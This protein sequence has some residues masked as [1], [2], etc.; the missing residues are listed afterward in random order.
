VLVAG[1]AHSIT[2]HL[3]HQITWLPYLGEDLANI[4]KGKGG[5]LALAEAMK[6]NFKLEKKKQGYAIS[7]INNPTFKVATQILASKMMQ[8]CRTDEV[9]A[10]MVALASQCVEG[11]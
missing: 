10:L 2:N 8:K 9:P 5:Y 11:D 3:I 4:S 1:G 6:K 7:S